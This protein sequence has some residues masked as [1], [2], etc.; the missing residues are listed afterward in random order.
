MNFLN[1]VLKAFVGD[2]SKKDIRLLQPLV[3]K[4]RSFDQEMENLSLDE[5]RGKTE[6]FKKQI[7]E[8]IKPFQDQ[9]E[10]LQKEIETAGVDRKEE[11]YK[12]IDILKDESYKASEE[13]LASIQSEAFAVMRETA[14]RFTT[15]TSL[16]VK[17]TAFDLSLIHI[18]EPTR[19]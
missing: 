5:L 9:I 8:G 11:I 3:D 10:A 16:K 17:A 4:V 1:S 14:R 2:K 15:N 13:V 18:S 19:H 7:S 12:E 6:D